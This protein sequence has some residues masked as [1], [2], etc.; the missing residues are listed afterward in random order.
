[1]S[2]KKKTRKQKI[3][4]GETVHSTYADKIAARGRKNKRAG[5]PIDTPT[6][7]REAIKE[8]TR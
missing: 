2:K 3:K 1:M 4:T 5:L 6:P 8:Y 7:V